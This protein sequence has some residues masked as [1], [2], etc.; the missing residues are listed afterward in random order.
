MKTSGNSQSNAVIR[1]GKIMLHN[2]A[3]TRPLT[4]FFL[5]FTA[6]TIVCLLFFPF[7]WM[8]IV[9][10]VGNLKQAIARMGAIIAADAPFDN[11]QHTLRSFF[12]SIWVAVLATIYSA[13]FGLVFA[14][15]MARNITPLKF[16][17]PVL[18]AVFTLIRSIPSFI[19]VLMVLVSLGFGPA[20]GITGL[21]I[22]STATF[23]R[24]FSHS[25]E[26]IGPETLEAI[27]ST[28][29]NRTKVFFAVVLPSSMTSIIAWMTT[30]LEGNFRASMMLGLVGAG[31]IGY[32]ITA[33]LAAYRYAKALVAIGIVIVFTFAVEIIFNKIKEKLK[34]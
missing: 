20:P 15:L 32:A 29:A 1:R 6:I 7:D 25:F 19:W 21:C 31:G 13:I 30:S 34:I 14:V 2:P 11:F 27:A 12:E 8:Q 23:A 22:V 5:A 18:G 33:A 28:G 17:S 3:Y 9:G 26:E 16:I 4:I 24:L 10:R